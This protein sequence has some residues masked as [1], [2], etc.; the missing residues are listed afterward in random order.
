MSIFLDFFYERSE[1][2][3]DSLHNE[4]KKKSLLSCKVKTTLKYKNKLLEFAACSPPDCKSHVSAHVCIEEN[5]FYLVCRLLYRHLE[6]LL[7]CEL[8]KKSNKNVIKIFVD[9]SRKWRDN[10]WRSCRQVRSAKIF[11]T[12]KLVFY[13]N[14]ATFPRF[15]TVFEN[16]QKCL[17][18]KF[19]WIFVLKM[20]KSAR[21]FKCGFLNIFKYLNFRAKNDKV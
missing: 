2:F 7:K 13:Q 21:K 12:K 1:H 8:L 20:S 16:H 4:L 3:P 9:N 15:N 17:I 18:L 19:F 10:Y 5:L 11:E 6:I 14:S